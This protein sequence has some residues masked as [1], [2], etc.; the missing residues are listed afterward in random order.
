MEFG[1]NAY[2][3]ICIYIYIYMYTHLYTMCILFNV[4][5]Q[6]VCYEYNRSSAADVEGAKPAAST[7]ASLLPRRKRSGLS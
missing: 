7:A 3:Y 6:Y 5:D 1:G 4:Y 2:T